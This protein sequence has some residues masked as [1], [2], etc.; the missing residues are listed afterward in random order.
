MDIET[1]EDIDWNK[2]EDLVDSFVQSL[3]KNKGICLKANGSTEEQRAHVFDLIGA[4]YHWNTRHP[5][6]GTWTYHEN[7]KFGIEML[8][9]EVNNTYGQ[10]IVPWH[11]E[12]TFFEYPQI[13]GGWFMHTFTC[14]PHVGRTGFVN[15]IELFNDLSEE[16]KD[17]LRRCLIVCTPSSDW[18][19]TTECHGS[20]QFLEQVKEGK[21]KIEITEPDGGKV[22]AFSKAAVC[23]H[24]V[25][26]EEIL[27][28]SPKNPPY[29]GD[30]LLRVDDRLP[31]NSELDHFDKINSWVEYEVRVNRQ[32]PYWYEWT[33]GDFLIVDLFCLIHGV[34]GGFEVGERI[35]T[36]FWAFQE[37]FGETGITDP[38][39][40]LAH[41][42]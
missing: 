27:R 35:F 19:D 18:G 33:Q 42:V 16:D 9:R 3:A 15:S 4:N 29:R 30:Y 20:I 14:S 36:G 34:M 22:P 23:Q 41:Y 28:I 39:Q 25:T 7:H 1:F 2:P 13:G 38:A 11:L 6:G 31:T 21:L 26:G 5:Q 40:R 37:K 24:P 32:R 8:L 17:F 12:N 10:I